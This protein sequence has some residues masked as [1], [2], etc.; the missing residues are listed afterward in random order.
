MLSCVELTSHIDFSVKA[1]ESRVHR[2]S[3]T[4]QVNMALLKKSMTRLGD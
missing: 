4:R 1:S 3:D 2:R